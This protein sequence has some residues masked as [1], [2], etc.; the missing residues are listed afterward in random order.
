MRGS[1]RAW[2]REVGPLVKTASG[3]TETVEIVGSVCDEVAVCIRYQTSLN[4]F[5][6]RKG[7]KTL[8]TRARLREESRIQ[9]QKLQL[10]A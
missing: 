2:K 7:V 1:F 9:I 5:K 10:E 6:K 4:H 8:K 3:K